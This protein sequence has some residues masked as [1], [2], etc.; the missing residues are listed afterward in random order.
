M[1]IKKISKQE[2]K[3]KT[4]AVKKIL[5]IKGGLYEE[6]LLEKQTEFINENISFLIEMAGKKEPKETEQIEETKIEN[7]SENKNNI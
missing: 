3:E 7:N 6:W 2:I 1:G 4:E 5:D